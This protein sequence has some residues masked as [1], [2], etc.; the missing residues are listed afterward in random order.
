MGWEIVVVRYHSPQSIPTVDDVLELATIDGGRVASC[1]EVKPKGDNTRRTSRSR[2][3]RQRVADEIRLMRQHEEQEA[4]RLSDEQRKAKQE[5]EAEELR[6]WMEEQDRHRKSDDIAYAAN[7][8]RWREE[9]RAR[10]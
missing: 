8:A 10:K 3:E 2:M 5:R 4:R 1:D 7:V 9:E 6:I